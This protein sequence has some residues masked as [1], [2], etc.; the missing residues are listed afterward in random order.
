MS[1]LNVNNITKYTG[2]EVVVNDASEDV[3][4]R[5]ESNGYANMLFVDG[6]NNTVG[7]NE[8]SNTRAFF[9]VTADV[10]VA[11]DAC[12]LEGNSANGIPL[13]LDNLRADAASEHTIHFFRDG[14]RFAAIGGTDTSLQFFNASAVTMQIDSTGAV[15]KPL[16]PAFLCYNSAVDATATGDGTAVT[17]DY[18]TEVFDQNS[19]FASDTFTAPVTGKYFLQVQVGLQDTEDATNTRYRMIL[20]TS[21]RTC[22]FHEQRVMRQD[23]GGQDIVLLNGS[24][25][26]DLDASD[27]A[28]VQA[29]VYGGTKVV[30]IWGNSQPETFFSGCLLA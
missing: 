28:Y 30:D 8:A 15:T 12:R 18:D 10:A 16:Q 11:A 3:D 4:F 6:G 21:N 5:V 1:Q 9:Q 26:A 27:T 14:S 2:G 19:D 22:V 24:I 7:I 17:I 23:D 20:V 29:A 25:V 13:V